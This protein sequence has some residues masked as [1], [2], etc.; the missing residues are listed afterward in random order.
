MEGNG[1]GRIGVMCID[2][3]AKHKWLTTVQSVR[4]KAREGH[5]GTAWTMEST[6][7]LLSSLSARLS[8]TMS[9]GSW[10][11]MLGDEVHRGCTP[12]SRAGKRFYL[13]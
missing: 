5:Q 7:I 10:C 1:F 11:R 12:K 3:E 9:Q 8:A 6:D 13:D 2:K 4:G